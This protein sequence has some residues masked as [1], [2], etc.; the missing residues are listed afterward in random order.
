[1]SMELETLAMELVL[2]KAQEQAHEKHRIGIEQKILALTGLPDEGSKTVEAGRYKLRVAQK[3]NRKLDDRA[4]SL[5]KDKIPEQ[6]RPVRVEEV[7]KLEDAGVRWLRDNEPG[8][9]A[10]L[11]QAMT[12]KPAKPSVIVEEVAR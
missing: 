12:E 8:Y 10:L 4:W 1:M 2:A 9:F 6:I 5:I 11:A 7:F 3:I